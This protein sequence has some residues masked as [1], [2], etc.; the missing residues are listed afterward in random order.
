[1]IL[2]NL[3][4]KLSSK[5]KGQKSENIAEK[6]LKSKG[7]KILAKNYRTK[8]G[9]IDI[10]A[11]KNKTLVFVEVKSEIEKINFSAE[12]KVDFKKK[13]KI[14]KVAEHFLV[15]NLKKLRKIED[16]RFDVIVVRFDNTKEE[17]IH[18]EG[19]FYKEGDL[20]WG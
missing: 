15:K 4:K 12:E 8:A 3:F 10:I 6:Y 14:F 11:I 18:Y 17:V 5:E 16:I 7:F 9:E 19:A 2:K 13:N 1:M 20:T